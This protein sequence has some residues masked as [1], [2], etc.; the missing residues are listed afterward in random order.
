MQTNKRH[1]NIWDVKNMDKISELK[2]III[3]L[4]MELVEANIPKGYCPYTYCIPSNGIEVNCATMDC[5]KCRRNFMKNIEE[6]IRKEV[7]SL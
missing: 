1:K 5:E 7:N 6:D 2:K 3:D 4:K